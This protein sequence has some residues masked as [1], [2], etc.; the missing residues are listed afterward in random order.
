MFPGYLFV[1]A[2]PEHIYPLITLRRVVQM[3]QVP[4]QARLSWEI[5]QVCRAIDAGALLDPVPYVARGW[6]VRVRTGPLKGVEG[7]V[8]RR[9]GPQRLLLQ[10]TTLGQAVGVDISAFDVDPLQPPAGDVVIETRG[11]LA[12]ADGKPL[13]F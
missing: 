5:T 12:G 3:I 4:D 1:R 2:N 10:I 9:T 11:G 13:P 8:E 6:Q 7:I